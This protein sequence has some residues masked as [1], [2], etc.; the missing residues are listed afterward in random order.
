MGFGSEWDID[1]D[2]YIYIYSVNTVSGYSKWLE[3]REDY[4]PS[5]LFLDFYNLI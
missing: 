3:N 4:S 2:I 5:V 1:G